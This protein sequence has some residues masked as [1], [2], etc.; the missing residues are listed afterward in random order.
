MDPN[1]FDIYLDS[2]GGRQS[3]KASDVVPVSSEDS[4]ADVM[5]E[6]FHEGWEDGGHKS[7]R[8]EEP[9][10]STKTRKLDVEVRLVAM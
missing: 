5:N 1:I 10:T 4:S 2:K 7:N 9:S 3:R 6:G 8:Q